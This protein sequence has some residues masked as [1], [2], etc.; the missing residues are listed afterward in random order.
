[1]NDKNQ[2][3]KG[4]DNKVHSDP[5]QMLHTIIEIREMKKL[6]GET[7][8]AEYKLLCEMIGQ[9]SGTDSK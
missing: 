7:D 9:N 1:M 3:D 8:D 2:I 4:R 6:K 5:N